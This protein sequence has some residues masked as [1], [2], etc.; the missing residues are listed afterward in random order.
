[1]TVLSYIWGAVVRTF[2]CQTIS[3]TPRCFSSLSCININDF[4][5]TDSG[6]YVNEKSLHSNYSEAE[7]FPEKLSLCWNEQV[8]QG[9]KYK[10]L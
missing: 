2:D 8:Y 9:V 10:A 1:M 4:L 6:G 3:F 7:C 5:A